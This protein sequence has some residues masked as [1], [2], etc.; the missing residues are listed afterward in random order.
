MVLWRSDSS[1]TG[2]QLHAASLNSMT[3]AKLHA[4]TA[5]DFG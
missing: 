1:F 4:L 5:K 2:K 3:F